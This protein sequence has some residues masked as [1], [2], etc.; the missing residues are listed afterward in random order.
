MTALS[1]IAA[2]GNFSPVNDAA[3]KTHTPELY[4]NANVLQ[5]SMNLRVLDL[6]QTS[7]H[8]E[9]SDS[10][11]FLDLGCG[12]GDMTLN[13]LLPRCQP[14]R[15]LLAVDVSRDMID[16][17]SQNSSHPWISH[18]VY[19]IQQD[20]SSLILKHGRFNRVYSFFCLQWVKDQ[21][22]AMKHVAELMVPG[23]ECLL[24]FPA[25]APVFRVWRRMCRMERW[26]QYLEL[27]ERHIPSSHDVMK[28][29]T[30]ILYM[31]GLLESAGLKHRTCEVISS[32]QG[33]NDLN[34]MI[35][36]HVAVNPVL[37]LV[38]ESERP[39]YLRE[40]KEELY[41]FWTECTPDSFQ[42]TADHFLV[43]AS[44]FSL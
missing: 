14:C 1:Q 31:E 23:G 37:P 28:K 13:H 34:R 30:L 43:H 32:S 35:D 22:T 3:V 41:N 6:L 29:T 16:Y 18:D 17:A 15:R 33:S 10:Q 11:Q 27:C 19:D 39:D 25:R 40:L 38:P 12:S 42:Y 8:A 36:C 24:F 44:K 7:F 26:K 4:V 9:L 21:R 5:R 20:P 2:S